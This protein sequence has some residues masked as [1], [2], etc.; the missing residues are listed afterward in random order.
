MKAYQV[1]LTALM[2][3]S[4]ITA[5]KKSDDDRAKEPV[6]V[7]TVKMSLSDVAAGR[8]YS[9]VIEESSGSMLSFSVPGTVRNIYVEAGTKVAKGQLLAELD[10]VTLRSN[11]EMAGAA[12]AT[13][14]DAYDRMKVL[15][16]ANAIPDIK[17]VE[18]ENAL[19]GAQSA[20]AIARNAL[21][22]TKLYAP[23]SGIISEKYVDAG[24]NAAPMVP[25]LKLIEI[26]PVKASI[27]VSESDVA[28]FTIG[29]EA[30]V[31]LDVAPGMTVAAKLVEKGVSAN[32]LSRTYAVKFEC[33]NPDGVLLPGMLCNVTLGADA[34]ESLYV[35]PASAV[36]LDADNQSFVW[37]VVDGKAQ[38]RVVSLGEY[39]PQGIVISDGLTDGD[40]VVV[41]GQQKISNGMDV[42]SIN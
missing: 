17:W 9:G 33:P 38:K 18:A 22:D 10:D 21:G 15:H 23:F 31:T 41:A 34:A 5:C 3:A 24:S 7:E 19:K 36:L 14:Q 39:V 28:N 37:T 6:R 35:L 4:L 1:I 40:V 2:V 8:V 11:C 27:S 30:L 29:S 13:A 12:L 32:P 16:D 26:S 25:A 42:T 20:Y